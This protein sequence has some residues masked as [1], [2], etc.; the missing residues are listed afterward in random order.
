MRT[1]VM[2]DSHGGY[3]AIRQ[4]LERAHF[5]FEKDTLICLGDVAD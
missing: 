4:V 2:G 5:D 3:R 1:L